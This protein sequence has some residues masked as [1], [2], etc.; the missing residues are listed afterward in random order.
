MRIYQNMHECFGEVQRDLKEMGITYVSETVQDQKGQFKTLEINNYGYT[1]VDANWDEARGTCLAN[2]VNMPWLE[3][4]AKDRVS[5][6]LGIKNPNPA[7]HLSGFWDKFFRDSCLAYTY[8]ER[9]HPQMDRIIHELKTRP[10]TRQAVMTMYD[11]HQDLMNFGG[12]DRIPCS[13]YYQFLLRDG[14]LH[15]SYTMRSCDLYKFFLADAAL[16]IALTKGIADI[17]GVKVG[18]F[19]HFIGSLHAFES[20]LG[21]IF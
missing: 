17:L 8:P 10:N 5:S 11:Q 13:M 21:D 16:A 3:Q 6:E 2:G 20:D 19:T 12:R 14:K 18:N 4:E 1:I 15:C 9:L 7:V